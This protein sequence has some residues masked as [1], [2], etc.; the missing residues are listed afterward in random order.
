[1]ANYSYVHWFYRDWESLGGAGKD[2][3]P[4]QKVYNLGVLHTFPNKKLSISF[5][6]KNI[7]NRQVFDNYALQR[8]GRALYFKINYSFI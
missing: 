2:I 8:P 6:V 3:I 7:L 4:T 5:D 1:M